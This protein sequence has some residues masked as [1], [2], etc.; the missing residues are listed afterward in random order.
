[1][2]AVGDYHPAF[3]LRPELQPPG[4]VDTQAYDV[5]VQVI[6]DA[7]GTAFAESLRARAISVLVEPDPVLGYINFKL[8]LDG[9]NVLD[10]ARDP[11]VFAVE[12][13]LE[14]RMLDERQG[15]IMAGNLDASGTQPSGP[16]YFSWLASMGLPTD[17]NDEFKVDGLSSGAS[18]L[19]YI[20]NYSGDPLG[21][22]QAG[23]GNINASIIC[24]YNSSTGTAFEDS[25]G[26]QYGLGIAPWVKIGDSKVFSN[27]GSGVFNQ[28]TGTRMAN[29]YNAGARISS[30]S[31]GYTSGTTY[32]TDSQAHD[33]AVRDA[34]SGTSGNQELTIVFAA[35]NSGSGAST[36]H[37][38]GTAKNIITVGASENWRMTGTDGCAI[39][40]TG[41]DNA[42]DIISF[43]S[44]GP[45]SDSRKKPEIVAPGTH[46]QGAASRAS[47]YSGAGVCNQYWPTGQTLY[48]W[49]SGTSHSTPA[50]S[51]ACALL[52]QFN[53]NHGMA[54]PSPAMSKASLIAG[55]SYLTGV[56]AN[57]TLWS[58]SQGMGLVNLGATFDSAAR[59]LVDQTQTFG[60][61]GRRAR[62]RA[63]PS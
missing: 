16:N 1:M 47:G 38:P 32:N 4:I 5:T 30:N 17:V 23:H 58:N 42:K 56:G 2:L 43:S 9:A 44:R 55:S 60:A 26:Y 62:R 35:G 31:W 36:V 50:I 18:R 29:A 59:I 34:V 12:P 52:R 61:T 45:T 14:A 11:H 10:L 19:A 41:A 40:N 53:L 28:P 49:S 57:D 46:I 13:V 22:G 39:A 20:N 6:A 8:R 25:L 3:K 27:S 21:D 51:G 37:P 33:V 48:A 15:Q 24:G 54:A 7:E 63:T